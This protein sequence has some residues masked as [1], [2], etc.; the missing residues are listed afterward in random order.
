MPPGALRLPV[1]CITAN[2]LEEHRAECKDAGMD[3]FITKPL[4]SDALGQLEAH[5]AAYAAQLAAGGAAAA[6][7]SL[8]A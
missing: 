4:R 7:S 3:G 5:A 2:V 6:G 8:Q 1:F